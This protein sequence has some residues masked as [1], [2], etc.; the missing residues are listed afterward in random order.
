MEDKVKQRYVESGIVVQKARKKARELAEPGANLKD[1]AAGI[2]LLIRDEGLKP[3]FPVNL[4]LNDEA[5][6][7]SPGLFEDRVLKESDVLKIDIG[8]QN[9][10]YIADTALTINPSGEKE[11]MI[12]TAEEVLEKALDFVEPGVTVGELGTFIQNQVPDQYNVVRNLTGHYIDKY[13][14]HAGVSIPNIANANTHVIQEGDALAIEPFLTT[15][16]GKIK[17][18]KKGNIYIRQQGKVRGRTERQVLK[19]ID[20]F[21]GLP[22]SPRWMDLSA[23][24]RVALKKLESASAVKHYPVLREV[25]GGTVVQAEHT[26]LVGVEDGDNIVTTM[27]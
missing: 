10:G 13:T 23:R 1:I 9:E 21:K 4:S 17:N 20:K 2:E 27:R 14:Q 11:E 16:S 22:F 25:E 24:E 19:K 26:V 5:A 7:Y 18:G 3:A 8:A 12:N 6:H 15:G